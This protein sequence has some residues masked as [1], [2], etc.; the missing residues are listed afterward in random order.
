MNDGAIDYAAVFQCLPG[1]VALLTP[2]LV[3]ADANE[4]FL[5]NAVV[6]RRHDLGEHGRG[7]I[8]PPGGA[9]DPIEH[10][11]LHAVALLIL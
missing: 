7:V 10:F 8:Q 3:F 11:G 9:Q 2:G 1:M 5:R 4:E 6:G